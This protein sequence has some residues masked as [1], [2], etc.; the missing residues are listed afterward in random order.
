MPNYSVSFAILPF[1]SKKP[2]CDGRFLKGLLISTER[3][4]R[5]YLCYYSWPG[6]PPADKFIITCCYVS[7]GHIIFSI[8]F[9]IF[10]FSSSNFRLVFKSVFKYFHILLLLNNY[11]FC[12]SKT[13]SRIS[14][15]SFFKLFGEMIFT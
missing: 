11:P 1:P 12:A 14:T 6:E 9:A 3:R 7:L 13:F 5:Y 4:N 2:T 15:Y 10:C 8:Y